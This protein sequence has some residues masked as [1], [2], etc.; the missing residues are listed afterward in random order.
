[1]T[2]T[3]TPFLISFHSHLIFR[4]C[5]VACLPGGMTGYLPTYLGTGSVPS[6]QLS[7]TGVVGQWVL[8]KLRATDPFMLMAYNNLHDLNRDGSELRAFPATKVDL[9]GLVMVE[10]A[11]SWQSDVARVETFLVK[12]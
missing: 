12:S 3:E 5:D 1:M 8:A 11:E 7:H 2:F 6:W 4:Y 9:S 10:A